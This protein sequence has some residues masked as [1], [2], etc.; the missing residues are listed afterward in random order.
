MWLHS[1]CSSWDGRRLPHLQP[2]TPPVIRHYGK[3]PHYAD[4]FHF[5]CAHITYLCIAK[6]LRNEKNP[7]AHSYSDLMHSICSWPEAHHKRLYIGRSEP[8][9]TYRSHHSGSG[10]RSRSHHQRIRILLDNPARRHCQPA[11]RLCRLP[12]AH[13][14]HHT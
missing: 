3:G 11:H 8:R 10:R 2:D 13:A 14:V 7:V 9:D 12:Y 6:P 5:L 4:L 1:S